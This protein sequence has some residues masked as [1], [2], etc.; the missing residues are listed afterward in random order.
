M[1]GVFGLAVSALAAL[2]YGTFDADRSGI[3]AKRWL[4]LTLGTFLSGILAGRLAFVLVNLDAYLREP[5]RLLELWRGGTVVVGGLLGWIAF[6]FL[7]TAAVKLPR[8][9]VADVIARC[10]ALSWGLHSLGDWILGFETR[11]PELYRGVVCL[12]TFGLLSALRKRARFAGQSALMFVAIYGAAKLVTDLAADAD[13]VMA[14]LGTTKQ[15]VTVGLLVAA[16]AGL[17]V[18]LR[19]RRAA[20][21]SSVAPV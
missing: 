4:Q 3:P 15:L 16:C 17:V 5:I 11:P 7:F 21:A 6:F 14:G 20:S 10:V 8:W 12:A 13:G 1:H 19:G 18:K 2:G 9:T